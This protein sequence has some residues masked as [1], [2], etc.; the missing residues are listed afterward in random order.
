VPVRGLLFDFDGLLVET[1]GP[2][3]ESWRW[4]YRQHGTDLPLALW[5]QVTGTLGSSFD[6]AV[7]LADL[8][9]EPVDIEAVRRLYWRRKLELIAHE[10]FRGL[11]AVWG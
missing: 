4:I 11:L 10:P 7:H 9:E 1:E 8:V 3:F 6:P 2:A 5:A